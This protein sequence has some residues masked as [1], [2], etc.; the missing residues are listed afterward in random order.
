MTISK[1]YE[2]PAPT[3]SRR[4]YSAWFT[5]HSIEIEG[6]IDNDG[7]VAHNR[8]RGT[9]YVDTHEGEELALDYN[10]ARR[11]ALA[12]L[13]AVEEAEAMKEDAR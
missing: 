11:V 6:D 7:A 4:T 13:A 1:T 10:E 12:L 9:I 2:L 3:T 8:S 5:G